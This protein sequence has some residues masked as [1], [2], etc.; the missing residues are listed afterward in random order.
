MAVL[1]FADLQS[2]AIP[3]LWDL[4]EIERVRL[5]DGTTFDQQVRDV[6]QAM[7]MLNSE[8]M[9]NPHYAAMMAVQ[10]SV[11]VEYPVGVTNGVEEAT[12]YGRPDPGQGATTG[13]SLPLKK[14]D[15]GLGWT[16]MML[17]DARR[18]KL[19]SHIRSAVTDIKN[20][21]QQKV[22][23]RFFRMEAERVGATTGASV[24]LADGGTA[25]PNYVPLVSDDG[26]VFDSTH[27]HFLRHAAINDTNLALTVAHLQE[28][29]HK[30]PYDLVGSLADVATWKGV[31]GWKAPN[32]SDVVYRVSSDRANIMD[33]E[34]YMGYI[35]TIYGLVRIWL[36]QRVPTA[37]YGVFKTYGQMDPR[38]P[39]RIRIN[40]NM[41]FGWMLVPGN[42][43]N[44]PTMMAVLYAEMGYG[45][46]EDRTNG[47]VVEIDSSGNYA[48]PTIS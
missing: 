45:I 47:V 17:R 5:A 35:E 12:E 28:H 38:N 29:G 16:M 1:G 39:V 3:D 26:E 46:G 8:L 14:W 40:P 10:D 7:A 32:W 23:Q 22:L 44:L 9:S 33:I 37:Y 13:H 43:V 2:L 21:F 24:P 48:T 42:W 20:D 27:S 31:T 6:Q 30:A 25:D 4:Q 15:R 19:D 18:T 36:T 34:M 11:E 41:G